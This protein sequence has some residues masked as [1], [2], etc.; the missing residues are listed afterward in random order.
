[1]AAGRPPARH[2]QFG[3]AEAAG[4]PA[5]HTPDSG[6]L[7]V[8]YMGNCSAQNSLGASRRAGTWRRRVVQINRSRAGVEPPPTAPQA[9]GQRPS[10]NAGLVKWCKRPTCPETALASDTKDAPLG[11]LLGTPPGVI[12]YGRYVMSP[13]GTFSP[14]PHSGGD[15]RSVALG[16]LANRLA[17]PADRQ[18]PGRREDHHK[19]V[20]KVRFPSRRSMAP[21]PILLFA[22]S[23]V[24]S[25]IPRG[26]AMDERT[27]L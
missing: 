26:R 6:Q 25:F 11:T 17:D 13:T 27:P 9:V 21:E 2:F 8:P 7:I 4:H 1:M 10:P 22:P 16:S 15:D 20:S 3:S 24:L 19:K 5:F 12:R 14:G 23:A 18:L